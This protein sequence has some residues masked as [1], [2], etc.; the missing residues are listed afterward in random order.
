MEI[1]LKSGTFCYFFRH[2][3]LEGIGI[4][5]TFSVP[6]SNCFFENKNDLSILSSPSYNSSIICNGFTGFGRDSSHY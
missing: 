5:I 6:Y 1:F 2:N 4:E 3:E